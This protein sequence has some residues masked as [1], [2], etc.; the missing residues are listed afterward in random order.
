MRSRTP[1]FAL[2]GWTLF[3]WATRIR[4][5]LGDDELSGGE[6][7]WAVGVATA[8]TLGGLAVLIAALRR[9]RLVP[10]VRVLAAVTAVYWPIRVV[11]IALADH[12][13]AFVVVHTVLGVVSVA[14]AA[15]A[16]AQTTAARPSK[17][18]SGLAV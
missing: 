11:Q 7:A 1:A 18:T 5:A 16:W 17:A 6:K 4:N 9:V 8:F 3:V 15:W 14:L 10:A 12:D 2:A 13:A